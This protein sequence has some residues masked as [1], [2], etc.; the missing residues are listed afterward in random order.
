[1]MMIDD[2]TVTANWMLLC[3]RKEKRREFFFR[4]FLPLLDF[5]FCC[6]YFIYSC[7]RMFVSA[8]AY[9]NICATIKKYLVN[10]RKKNTYIY[11]TIL[12]IVEFQFCIFI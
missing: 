5:F 8:S 11:Y 6:F 2:T 1:M 4:R 12:T 10:K 9:M 3:D 7:T